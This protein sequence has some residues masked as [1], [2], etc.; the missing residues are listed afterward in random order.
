[1]QII[2]ITSPD[3]HDPILEDY[4]IRELSNTIDD[5]S[6]LKVCRSGCDFSNPSG[7]LSEFN[8]YFLYNEGKDGKR[9][10]FVR[11]SDQKLSVPNYNRL[12]SVSWNCIIKESNLFSLRI[13]GADLED[14]I[15]VRRKFANLGLTTTF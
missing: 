4:E 13:I 3:I 15:P 9:N 7:P 5:C 11:S 12:E 6:N 1:M 2:C 10:F 8:T 14:L